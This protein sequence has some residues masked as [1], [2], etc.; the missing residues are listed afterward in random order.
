MRHKKVIHMKANIMLLSGISGGDE[1]HTQQNHSWAVSGGKETL[2]G[3]RT[4]ILKA[5][6]LATTTH[7]RSN[8]FVRKRANATSCSI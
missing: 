6:M 3:G 7:M 5:W 4:M 8:S 1:K 2:K